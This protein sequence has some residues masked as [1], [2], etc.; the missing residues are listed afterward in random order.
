MGKYSFNVY[1][2]EQKYELYFI[3]VSFQTIFVLFQIWI[4]WNII[5]ILQKY[6]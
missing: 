1:I 5:I 6:K 3:V 4:D 2:Q